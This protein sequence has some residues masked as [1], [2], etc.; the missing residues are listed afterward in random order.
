MK[1]SVTTVISVIKDVIRKASLYFTLIVILL[2]I[3]GGV[4]GST[5]FAL[6]ILGT[7][8]RLSF[9]RNFVFTIGFASLGAG[10]A[11]QIF[12]LTKIPAFSRHIAF[13]ILM[14]ANFF[15][16]MLPLSDHAPNEGT[17]LYLSIVFIIIY[18]IIFGAY[19]G[20]RSAVNAARNRKSSYNKMFE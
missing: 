5:E 7:M 4:F 16:I 18:L 17:T 19:M 13:F 14:Y 9:A 2:N 3:L 8:H 10:I 20:A 6:N 12:R 11:A 1:L 15:L